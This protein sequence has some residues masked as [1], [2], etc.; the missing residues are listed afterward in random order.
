[1]PPIRTKPLLICGVGK[2]RKPTRL[3]PVAR[4]TAEG[5]ATIAISV[6]IS[7]AAGSSSNASAE[8]RSFENGESLN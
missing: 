3:S 1:M 5:V 6:A 7:T 8:I 2:P 4:S